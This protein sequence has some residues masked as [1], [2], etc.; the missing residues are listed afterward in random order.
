ALHLSLKTFRHSESL[1]P[2]ANRILRRVAIRHGIPSSI[3]SMVKGEIPARLA[4]SALLSIL[5]SRTCLRLFP[6]SIS[7][8]SRIDSL[9][10]ALERPYTVETGLMVRLRM[11]EMAHL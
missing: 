10:A 8:S 5:A 9:Q 1:S 4:N 3:R 7:T 6:G 2:K 11:G